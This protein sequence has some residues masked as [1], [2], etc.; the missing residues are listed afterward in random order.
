MT[1]TVKSSQ[2]ELL[3]GVNIVLANT[4]FGTVTNFDGYYELKNIPEGKYTL[5]AS[6][7]GYESYS[8]NIELGSSNP[9]HFSFTLTEK[10]YLI[11][12]I[13][14]SG[15][16]VVSQINEQAYSVTSVS[17]KNL[18]NSTANVKEVLN[19]IPGVRI[20][21]EGGMG[22]NTNFTINGFSGD[23]VKFF[24]DGLPMDNFGSS[25][26]FADIPVNMIERIDVYKGVVPVWLGTDA[27]GGAVNIITN[28]KQNFLDLS[29][30][31]GSFNTHKASV[32]FA[33]TNTNSGFTLRGNAF[34][35]YSNNNYKVWVP[36]TNSNNAII[37][38]A[39]VER[40]HDRYRSAAIKIE[41]GLTDKKYADNLLFGLM[42]SANDK[43]VQH[44]ATMATVYGGIVQ[45]SQSL[46]PTFRYN[47][48]DLFTPGLDVSLYSAINFKQ[49]QVIDTLSGVRFNWLGEAFT[50][51]GSNDG[52]N[53]R[54]FTTLDD[55]EF[56]SQFNTSY[57]INAL[58]SIAL[59]YSYNYFDRESFDEENPDYLP[60][61]F[62][63]SLNK[64]VAGLA[65]K[66]D[67]NQKW[68]T[69]AFAKLLHL[70]AKTSKLFDFGLETQRTEAVE[71]NKTNIGYGVA[72][73]YYL[74][75]KLQ[76]KVSY[77]H[78]FRMPT[79]LEIFGDGLFID[80]NPDL[81]PEQSDNLNL[82]A[83]Y[84]FKLRG[85][86][87]INTGATFVY[88]EAKDLIYTVVQ[89]ASP[90]TYYDNLN[91]TR[92]LGVESNIQYQYKDIFH[93]GANVTYQDITDQAEF[94]YDNSYTNG[95]W[96]KNFHYQYRVP[97]IP[98]LFGSAN[99]GLNFK[100][101]LNEGDDFNIN[102]FF[103]YAQNYYLSW[104]KNPKYIIPQQTSHDV[105]VSYAFDNGKYN[106]SA[107]C[108]NLLN[109]RLYDKYYLQKPGRAFSIKFRYTL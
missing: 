94:V 4:E 92:T 90:V 52:E 30:S 91:Q 62:Q 44:G 41:S 59:N 101:M 2:G 85:N 79:P 28:K 63:R 14:V 34:I 108:R 9:G 51:E 69:T 31:Y 100:N 78:T 1:G 98:F 35:N 84:R 32:N 83:D 45:N 36:I 48:Q 42:A 38:T 27:L 16:S 7:L 5:K 65:Y 89:I 103:N 20:T 18:F 17:T 39:E 10:S 70:N 97:N 73:S 72:S 3:P 46:I 104:S 29:Y 56:L 60:N 6:S 71:S 8:S 81:G 68:S 23:Q 107:E 95:G 61:R 82:G 74:L 19:K 53:S 87:A 57:T 33:H 49:S 64:H 96:K 55:K 26:S 43:E 102:Y 77:E 80:P 86:H 66:L 11:N 58:H 15:K 88:R 54:T 37:D 25:L 40:F 93:L 76:V 67:V 106:I 12:D 50:I 24:M 109:A 75:P 13:E 105:M 99:A 22:S 47:K 21:E